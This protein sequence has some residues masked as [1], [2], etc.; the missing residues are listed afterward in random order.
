[1]E[2]SGGSAQDALDAFKVYRVA[3]MEAEQVVSLQGQFDDQPIETTLRRLVAFANPV[4]IDDE[5]I[6]NRQ[7]HLT[8]S[9]GGMCW[10]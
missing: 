5:A 2:A 3:E 8:P 6:K 1:M 4:G 9:A 10:P 7:R